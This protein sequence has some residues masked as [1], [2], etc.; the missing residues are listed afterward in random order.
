[1]YSGSSSK[2]VLCTV[3]EICKCRHLKSVTVGFGRGGQI[4][5][6]ASEKVCGCVC[7]LLDVTYGFSA[8]E[9]KKD[10]MICGVNMTLLQGSG[11]KVGQ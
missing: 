10:P 7:E 11:M 2:S 4:G 9:R 5:G 8:E 1:M 6:F 3:L